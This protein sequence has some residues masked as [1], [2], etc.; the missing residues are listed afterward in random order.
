MASALFLLEERLE[1][2]LGVEVAWMEKNDLELA[3][4]KTEVTVL[5]NKN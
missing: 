3:M 2:E 1:V 4:E 5:T